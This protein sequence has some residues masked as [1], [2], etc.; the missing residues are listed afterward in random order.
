MYYIILVVAKTH[1]V[2]GDVKLFQ[3]IIGRAGLLRVVQ[4]RSDSPG[5]DQR[6]D[7]FSQHLTRLGKGLVDPHCHKQE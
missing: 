5:A 4:N 3:R 2:E 6:K 1:M 7:Q